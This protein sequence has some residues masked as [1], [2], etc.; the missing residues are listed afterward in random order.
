M[1]AWVPVLTEASTR[2]GSF[3]NSSA[4]APTRR[5]VATNLQLA[6]Y[7]R[8]VSG[9]DTVTG[10]VGAAELVQL[11]IPAGVR[12]PGPK[13]QRQE[14]TEESDRVLDDALAH[15]VAT[16]TSGEYPAT[17][18]P[19]CTYCAFTITCPAQPAGREVIG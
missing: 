4:S 17:P 15:A 5:E 16:I 19:A 3:S 9:A 12:D 13:V 7:R 18:G 11:R 2:S 10:P 8:L 6:T 14:A 1:S